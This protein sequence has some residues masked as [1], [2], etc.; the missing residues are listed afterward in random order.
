MQYLREPN[1]SVLLKS[2]E[3]YF[4]NIQIFT[5]PIE[6]DKMKGISSSFFSLFFFH[7]SIEKSLV[8]LSIYTFFFHHYHHP[9]QAQYIFEVYGF[10]GTQTH[11]CSRAQDT[12]KK[13]ILLFTVK[14]SMGEIF[15]AYIFRLYA[16]F[17]IENV[18]FVLFCPDRIL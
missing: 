12:K 7:I 17:Y 9:F 3:H 16:L 11:T 6:V 15:L 13:K 18:S 10:I 4:V 1:R 5:C 2:N 14:T 8:R